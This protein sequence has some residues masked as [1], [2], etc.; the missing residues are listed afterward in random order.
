MKS[1]KKA[2]KCPECGG[3]VYP[4]HT[5]LVYELAYRVRINNVPANICE[6]CGEVFIAGRVASEVNRLVNE[7]SRTLKVLPK[8]SHRLKD[9]PFPGRLRSRFEAFAPHKF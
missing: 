4:G 2:R 7:S 8:A 5:E 1:D 6:Q 3:P 9:H